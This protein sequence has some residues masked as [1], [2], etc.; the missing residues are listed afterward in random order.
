MLG[1]RTTGLHLLEWIW[2][3][4]KDLKPHTVQGFESQHNQDKKKHGQ[5]M[6]H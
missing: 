4:M 6:Q 1:I 3:I 5:L 2:A